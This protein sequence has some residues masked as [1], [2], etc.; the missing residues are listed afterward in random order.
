MLNPDGACV[1]GLLLAAPPARRS[2]PSG[3]TRPLGRGT[4]NAEPGRL[5]AYADLVAALLDLRGSG[6]TRAFDAALTDAVA[7]GTI[8]DDLSRQLRWLQR[9]GERAI[10]EHAEAVLP[11]AL[12]ALQANATD[13]AIASMQPPAAPPVPAQSAL[14]VEPIHD[15]EQDELDAVDEPEPAP[16]VQLESRRLLVAGLRPITDP[17]H[18]GTLP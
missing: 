9:A 3:S 17:A 6:P 8:S 18:R 16:V 13:Q 11:P 4:V 15:D 2:L 7:S 10:V 14:P 1:R 12:V 5:A